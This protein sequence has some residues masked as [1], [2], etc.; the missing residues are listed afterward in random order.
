MTDAPCAEPTTDPLE[1]RELLRTSF[2]AAATDPGAFAQAFYERLFHLAPAARALFQEDIGM[3]REKFAQTLAT[4]IAYLDDPQ[5]LAPEL[6]RLGARHVSYGAEA[7]HYALVGEALLDTLAM[8]APDGL[9]RRARTAWQRLYS[10]I[11]S[12]MLAG[13]RGKPG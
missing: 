10:W 7:A 1:G 9:D 8:A 3:Q 11:A 2:A 13:A 12:E 4:V 5:A 6:R